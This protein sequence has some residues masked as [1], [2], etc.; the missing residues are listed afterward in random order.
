MKN[1]KFNVQINEN[2][3][4][5]GSDDLYKKLITSFGKDK[6]TKI[7]FFCEIYGTHEIVAGTDKYIIK[8][9]ID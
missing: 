4:V 5:L 3:Q 9:I 6:A 8:K 2:V 1:T 7:M